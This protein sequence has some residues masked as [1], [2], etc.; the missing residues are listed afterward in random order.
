MICIMLNPPRSIVLTRSLMEASTSC[1]HALRTLRSAGPNLVP[2]YCKISVCQL[3]KSPDPPPPAES[4]VCSVGVFK[5]VRPPQGSP[6]SGKRIK[7]CVELLEFI[8][9]QV[10]HFFVGKFR[11]F[12]F[13][14]FW[15]RLI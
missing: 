2:F 6:V 9:Y 3:R 13:F 10:H 5:S 15:F 8:S 11:C 14:C 4:G 12:L 7:F 1:G